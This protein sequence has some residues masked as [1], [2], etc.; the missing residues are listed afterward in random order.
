MTSNFNEGDVRRDAGGKF[1]EFVRS[2]PAGIV[3][4][5]SLT[6]AP[7]AAGAEVYAL[8]DAG[9]EGSIE[10]YAGDEP[11][12]P[13]G[14]LE[15]TSPNGVT[16]YLIGAGTAN[17]RVKYHDEHD[18]AGAFEKKIESAD[19]EVQADLVREALWSVDL[20]GASETG[21]WTGDIYENRGCDFRVEDGDLTAIAELGDYDQGRTLYLVHDFASGSTTVSV[22]GEELEGAV[23]EAEVD[24]IL[25]DTV[26]GWEG[27]REQALG[28]AFRRI[29]AEVPYRHASEKMLGAINEHLA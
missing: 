5:G 9:L 4:P 22:E 2:E 29:M 13:E 6:I 15:Y 23:R 1:S 12:T 3:M 24:A 25:N 17:F 18:L 20:W 7:S 8:A 21:F 19:P 10:R 27:D 26:E 28:D 16:L 14:S 11:D